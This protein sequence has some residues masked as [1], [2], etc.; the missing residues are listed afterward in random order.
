MT[1]PAE[2]DPP[3]TVFD[4]LLVALQRDLAD[5]DV[6]FMAVVTV[7]SDGRSSRRLVGSANLATIVGAIEAAKALVLAD[8]M[9]ECDTRHGELN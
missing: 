9:S 4:E 1:K 5:G 6:D 2:T 8:L 3:N 7:H